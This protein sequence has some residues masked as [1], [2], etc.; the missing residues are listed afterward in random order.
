MSNL[1]KNNAPYRSANTRGFLVAFSAANSKISN[2]SRVMIRL[3]QEGASPDYIE[4][5]NYMTYVFLD[6]D[7]HKNKICS[8]KFSHKWISKNHFSLSEINPKDDPV[9]LSEAKFSNK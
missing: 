4:K 7:I 3:L 8:N 5:F 2:P 1:P 6:L 9:T